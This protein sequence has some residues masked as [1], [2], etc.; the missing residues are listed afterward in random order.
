MK[1]QSEKYPIFKV[2]DAIVIGVL[3]LFAVLSFIFFSTRDNGSVALIERDG[4][5]LYTVYLQKGS[6][7]TRYV[8]SGKYPLNIYAADG[9]IWF[10]EAA[11]PDHCCIRYGKLSKNGETA[12]C[13]PAGVIIRI[14]NGDGS[15]DAVTG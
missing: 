10:G 3:L 15:N 4:K 11:C 7:E 14:T 8:I 5:V 13:L 2:T 12:A 9:K 1:Q 6:G